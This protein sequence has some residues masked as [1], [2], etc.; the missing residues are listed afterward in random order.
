MAQI[1]LFRM[2]EDIPKRIHGKRV[3]MSYLYPLRV[4]A[5]SKVLSTYPETPNST[6]EELH[7]GMF[8]KYQDEIYIDGAL[9]FL[10]I[11]AA[12]PVKE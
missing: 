3:L 5:Q 1:L 4:P 10:L 12:E 8:V 9:D 2:E 6:S 11:R 7:A